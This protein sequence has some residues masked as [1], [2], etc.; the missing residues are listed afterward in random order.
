MNQNTY[1]LV[2]LCIFFLLLGNRLKNYFRKKKQGEQEPLKKNQRTKAARVEYP[3]GRYRNRE[4]VK[5][6]FT[7]IVIAV[8]TLL[9]MVLFSE[10]INDLFI[11]RKKMD[12]NLFMCILI[13]AA[14]VFTIISSYK[15]VRKKK[16]D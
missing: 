13:L 12:I 15:I 2:G 4:R 10:L 5:R 7:Y 9:V 16:K 11:L 3:S 6:I 14:A 1:I 8:L